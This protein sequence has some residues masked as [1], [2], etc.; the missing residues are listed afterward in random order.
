MA[1]L[2]HGGNAKEISR[3]MGINYNDIIDFSANINPLGMPESVKEAI[4]NN[5]DAATKYPD[6]T[7]FELRN[8]I[9]NFENFKIHKEE[10]KI[11]NEEIILGN[12]AAEVLFNIVKA[13]EPKNVLIPAPTFSEYEEAVNAVNGKVNLYY[14]RKENEFEI[15]ED[16]LNYI[17]K[18]IDLIFICNPNNPTGVITDKKLLKKVLNKSL[19]NN[20]YVV[21]DESFLDFVREDYSMI[22]FI[23]S[24]KN[25]IIIK[26][27]TKFFA[28]P[29]MRAGYGISTDKQL[30]SKVNKITPA[31]NIN[32]LAEEAVKAALSD[33]EYIQ[34]SIEFMEKEKKYMYNKLKEIDGIKVFNPS[35]NFI[36]FKRD[37]EEDWSDLNIKDKLLEKN[38]LIRSCN[39]YHRLDDTYY[40]I[41]IRNHKD[42]L[43]LVNTLKRIL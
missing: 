28:I 2:G 23:K 17:D 20:V 9:R 24:Y 33:K 25:L 8:S 32:I 42:N 41:A 22:N 43:L 16:I 39:N 40:R 38:I 6:I 29:G 5:L 3:S 30:L 19:E 31:W 27:L 10:L 4:I 36:F 7:Y 13:I 21:I 1:N 14:L 12:G 34:E 15:Q 18:T 35:V 37:L 11:N 26:S